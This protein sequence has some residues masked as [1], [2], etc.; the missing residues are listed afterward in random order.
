MNTKQ[1]ITLLILVVIGLRL[2]VNQIVNNYT[3]VL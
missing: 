3:F 1:K 2:I